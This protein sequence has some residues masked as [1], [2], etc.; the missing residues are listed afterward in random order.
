MTSVVYKPITARDNQPHV[1][2]SNP[3]MGM[4]VTFEDLFLT[5]KIYYFLW[6]KNKKNAY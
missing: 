3:G 4:A 1:V 2:T 5:V 6:S